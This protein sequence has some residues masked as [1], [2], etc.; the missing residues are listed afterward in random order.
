MKLFA[1]AWVHICHYEG[2]EVLIEKVETNL[3]APIQNPHLVSMFKYFLN[4]FDI[5]FGWAG[6]LAISNDKIFDFF[7][8]INNLFL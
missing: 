1:L 3:G 4:W 2:I 7:F 8:H 5:C 6:L